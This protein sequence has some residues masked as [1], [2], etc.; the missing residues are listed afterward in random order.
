[1][2]GVKEIGVT[3]ARKNSVVD[4]IATGKELVD[5]GYKMVKGE[6]PPSIASELRKLPGHIRRAEQSR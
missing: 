2:E 5:S 1:L 3:I 4:N 6:E